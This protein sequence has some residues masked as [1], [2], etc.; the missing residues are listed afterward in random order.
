MHYP[1][2]IMTAVLLIS[3]GI[4]GWQIYEAIDYTRHDREITC[5]VI[6][7]RV[8]GIGHCD[9][10]NCFN[11]LISY[12]VIINGVPYTRT[13]SFDI[14]S[15]GICKY[16]TTKCYYNEYDPQKTLSIGLVGVPIYTMIALGFGIVSIVLIVF[17]CAMCNYRISEPEVWMV[18]YKSYGS[19]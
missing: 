13:S 10:S 18:S 19:I 7:C 15:D 5:N 3:L 4:T 8:T 9:N 17:L 14:S 6:T 11:I 16:N 2:W 1:T 12:S